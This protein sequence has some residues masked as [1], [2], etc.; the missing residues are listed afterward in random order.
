MDAF[1]GWPLVWQ[2]KKGGTAEELKQ[3]LQDAFC[4]YG[5][6]ELLTSDGGPQYTSIIIRDFLEKWGVKHR[7]TAAYNPHAN[8][9]AETGVKS[10]KRILMECVTK[11]DGLTGENAKKALME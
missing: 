7:I 6:P 11:G 3:H 2:A 8:M 4:T 9:R 1:T 10:M 5:I